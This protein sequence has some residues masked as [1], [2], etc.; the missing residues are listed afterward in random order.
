MN[1]GWIKL[2][3]QLKFKGYYKKPYYVFLWIHL[4]LS[5]NHIEDT[6]LWDGGEIT[7]KEG[8]LLTGRKQLSKDTGIPES[9]IERI[10]NVLENEHQIE[11][12]KTTKFRIITILNWHKFQKR[13]TKRTTDGQ[14]MDT[15]K[16]NKNNKNNIVDKNVHIQV[17]DL[18]TLYK[19]MFLELISD[20]PP[21]FAWGKCE[22][23]AK[24]LIRKYGQ[25]RMKDMLT[26]YL[27]TEDPFYR[28]SNW[29][30]EVFLASSTINA[31]L[32]KTYGGNK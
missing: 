16:N 5:A 12:Q 21:H 13:T 4:L 20:E 15:N 1:N 11:Q 9:T 24:P 17:V 23:L 29:G 31:L 26:A 30:L 18:F 14:Q 28:K 25:E 6:F 32:P 27:H 19:Q 22:K 7:I 8:Q 10:L 2:H 3:R